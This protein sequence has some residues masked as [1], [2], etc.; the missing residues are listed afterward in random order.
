MLYNDGGDAVRAKIWFPKQQRLDIYVDGMLMNPNNIDTTQSEYSLLPPDDTFI[1]SLE[2]TNGANYFDP[3]SGHLYLIVKGPSN[4][5]I[6]TQPIVVLKLGM[7]VPIENFFEENVVANL[8]GL[9]GIDPSNIRVTN[10]VREGSTGRKKRSGETITGIEFEIGP[11]PSDTLVEFIPEEYTNPPEAT[12]VTENPAY[13]T[14]AA[15]ESTTTAWVPPANHL[16]FD[17]LASVSATIANA[18]QTGSLGADMGLNV[19]GLAVE[20]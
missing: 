2:E 6:K 14:T 1:P 17:D 7:T 18:F 8:A 16:S 5:E 15:P 12:E 9:L 13:T 3:N 20:Q 19:T 4:I 11:P 10:I